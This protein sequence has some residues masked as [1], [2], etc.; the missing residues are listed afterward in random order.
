VTELPPLPY[1]IGFDRARIVRSALVM[2]AV[3]A[4]AGVVVIQLQ[5]AR[6][7]A[8]GQ[9]L[10]SRTLG[11]VPLV[12]VVVEAAALLMVGAAL[13]SAWQRRDYLLLRA[14]GIEFHNYHGVFFVD[15]KNVARL[16]RAP[17][18][19]VGV[20]LRSSRLCSR[21]TRE[22]RSSGKGWRRWSR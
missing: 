1:R 18:G 10:A 15:W 4:V 3:A 14:D 8:L 22:P 11:P 19:Y 21:R 12:F 5:R 17:A 7:S 16:E 2:L 6:P 13:C 9:W 20:Q